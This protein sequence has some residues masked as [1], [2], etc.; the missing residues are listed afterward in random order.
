[1]PEARTADRFPSPL[2]SK[3]PKTALSPAAPPPVQKPR[4]KPRGPVA[5]REQTCSRN[6]KSPRPVPSQMPVSAEKPFPRES[7][8]GFPAP[9]TRSPAS[10]SRGTAQ[11]AAASTRR[12]QSNARAAA[13]R[14]FQ[15]RGRRSENSR[16]KARC[17]RGQGSSRHKPSRAPDKAKFRDGSARSR[18]PPR[19]PRSVRTS[20]HSRAAPPPPAAADKG[21]KDRNSS[22]SPRFSG[23]K[24]VSEAHKAETPS[25]RNRATQPVWQP[26]RVPVQTKRA[27]RRRAE[28]AAE[29]G[30]G[31]RTP[32]PLLQTPGPWAHTGR[33]HPAS[34]GRSA[35]PGERST[36]AQRQTAFR[37]GWFPI[38][39]RR[40]ASALKSFSCFPLKNRGLPQRRAL[41]FPL[42]RGP[43]AAYFL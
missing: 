19:P 4:R 38:G 23:R 29:S 21:R 41:L 25:T 11:S 36:A 2:K 20:W 7:Q 24:P 17:R 12:P 14:Q 9:D 31:R 10:C 3:T 1:M 26:Q 37:A 27:L 15:S 34:A 32:N 28:T 16:R 42:S 33:R 35:G 18:P 39:G 22:R 43:M 6:P 13:A 40:P 30:D 5:P 8:T